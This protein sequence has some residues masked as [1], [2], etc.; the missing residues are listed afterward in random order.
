M[1]NE[2]TMPAE[3]HDD[4]VIRPPDGIE[5]WSENLFFLP[6]DFQQGI[7]VAMHLGRSGQDPAFWR[8]FI[9]IYLPGGE[10]VV[11]KSF[12]HAVDTNDRVGPTS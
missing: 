6:F 7:G 12:G 1:D 10:A 8:E 4:H 11:A 2:Q 3:P 9:H 5:G